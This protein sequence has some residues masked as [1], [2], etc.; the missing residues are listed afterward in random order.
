MQH[1]SRKDFDVV[2]FPGGSGTG[3]S[4][5]LGS[6]GRAA[7]RSFVRSGGGYIGT[8]GGAYLGLQ[9]LLFYGS[10]APKI[11]GY[12]NACHAHGCNVT[13]GFSAEA[14]EELSLSWSPETNVTSMYHNGPLIKE[15]SL[16]VNVSVLARFRA[17]GHPWGA[18]PFSGAIPS[19]TPA[20]T[21]VEFGA[22]KVVLNSPHPE[23]LPGL[24]ESA[25]IYSGE[26]KWVHAA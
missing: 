9:H 5:A 4:N 16:P 8:C 2:V 7:V 1:V 11:L 21:A 22:G 10:P 3:Q 6:S 18:V 19:G 26:L 24:P 14:V 15:A 17:Q 12:P 23:H 25:E 20:I 13:L